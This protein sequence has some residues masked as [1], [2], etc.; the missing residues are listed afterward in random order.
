MLNW[1][2]NWGRKPAVDPLEE[3]LKSL[4]AELRD[5]LQESLNYYGLPGVPYPGSLD[6]L[7]PGMSDD[8]GFGYRNRNRRGDNPQ[9]YLHDEQLKQVRER[10]R[11]LAARNEYARNALRVRQTYIVG[12]GLRTTAMPRKNLEDDARAVAAAD[13]VQSFLEVWAAYTKLYPKQKEFQLRK[14]RD[15]EAFIRLFRGKRFLEYN[16]I[17]PEHVVDYTGQ[18]T[19]GIETDPDDITKIVAY[20]V[21]P[22]E[23]GQPEKVDAEKVIHVKA[24]VDSGIKRGLPFLYPIFNVLEKIESADENM[25]AIMKIQ[26]SIAMIRRHQVARSSAVSSGVSSRADYTGNNP[27]TGATDNYKL[28]RPGTILDVD[29]NTEYEFPAIAANLAHMADGKSS[30]LRSAAAGVGM[31]EY[32]LTADA[33]NGNFASTQVAESPAIADFLGLQHDTGEVFGAGVYVDG[34]DNGLS[35]AAIAYAVEQGELNPDV[36]ELVTLKSEGPNIVVRDR[37]QETQRLSLLADKGIISRDEW[38]K[39]EGREKAAQTDEEVQAA[40]D[41]EMQKQMALKQPA[42]K[43]VVK[44]AFDED[45]HPRDDDGKFTNKGGDGEKG[46]KK[47]TKKKLKK[48]SEAEVSMSGSKGKGHEAALAARLKDWFPDW[49]ESE[50]SVGEVIASI[51]GMPD[52]ATRYDTNV[53]FTDNGRDLAIDGKYLRVSVTRKGLAM[54]RLIGKDD[55]GVFVVNKH[56]EMKTKG[57][58]TGAELFAKQVEAAASI[59]VYEIRCHAACTDDDGKRYFNGYYTWPRLGYDQPLEGKGV[60]ESDKETYN[61]AKERF[62]GAKTVLDIMQTEEGRQWW[63]DNGTDMLEARFDLS[64]GSRS[65]KIHQAYMEAKKSKK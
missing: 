17:E 57:K 6:F 37:N 48:T 49:D 63:K 52:D 44:E 35:W 55:K 46:E 45:E 62:P 23:Q 61:A 42:G 43:P 25:A 32:M 58:G 29:N 24:N 4:E 22:D 59:G 20:Y 10:S 56:F 19:F 40:K 11:D 18:Y 41:A 34:A 7:R 14:D 38:A 54:E 50:A 65:L 51:T 5:R 28:Y 26:G 33:A 60:H 39:A 53:D 3:K 21:R 8:W 47:T 13:E 15:G 12:T 1:L 64:E 2:T 9:V 30:L 16:F 31:P 27:M 36:L